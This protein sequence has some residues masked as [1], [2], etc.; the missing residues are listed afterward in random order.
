MVRQGSQQDYIAYSHVTK[1]SHERSNVN[2]IGERI[3]R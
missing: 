2:H 3:W 1:N